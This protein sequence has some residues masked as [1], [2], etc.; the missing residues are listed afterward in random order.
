VVVAGV[1]NFR[2]IFVGGFGFCSFFDQMPL[3]IGDLEAREGGEGKI[4]LG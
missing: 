2:A 4:Y 3:Q 1:L